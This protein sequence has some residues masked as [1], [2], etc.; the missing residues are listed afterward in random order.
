MPKMNLGLWDKSDGD[1]RRVYQLTVAP[2]ILTTHTEKGVIWYGSH[3]HVG[4]A[5]Y[6]LTHMDSYTF[7]QALA[8]FLDR[9]TLTLEDPIADPYSIK[10]K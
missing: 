6:Q 1:F 9:T 7:P 2:S 4:Q 3:E 10:L 5:A 8:Y